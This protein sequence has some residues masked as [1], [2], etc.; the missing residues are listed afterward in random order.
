MCFQ[1][2]RRWGVTIH[3]PSLF[4]GFFFFLS[5]AFRPTDSSRG[6]YG[7]VRDGPSMTARPALDAHELDA[8]STRPPPQL[9][10]QHRIHLMRTFHGRARPVFRHL[11]VGG[12]HAVEA[13]ELL[14]FLRRPGWYRPGVVPFQSFQAGAHM[15]LTR[16]GCADRPNSF[17]QHP[18]I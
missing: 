1:A 12:S 15:P 9:P 18:T 11:G 3:R 6:G 8:P 14:F 5:I 16:P 10:P 13:N 2:A 4:L 7:T 17:S